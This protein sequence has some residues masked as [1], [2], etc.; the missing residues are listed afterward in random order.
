M[1]VLSHWYNVM[2]E[3]G[4]IPREQILGKEAESKVPAEFHAQHRT[5]AN[6]PTMLL[7]I[8]RLIRRAKADDV[9]DEN[10]LTF[11]KNIYP[12]L[13]LHFNWWVKTQAGKAPNSFRWRGRKVNHTLSS[14]LDDYPR[15][16]KPSNNE[17][18]VDGLCWLI[19]FSRT[20]SDIARL[21][22]NNNDADV[23]SQQQRAFEKT[24][25]TF[26]WNEKKQLYADS[27]IDLKY[28]PHV[29]LGI[30]PKNS[31][32]LDEYLNVINDSDQLWS[33]WGILSLSRNDS[34]F[35]TGENYWK[36][37]IW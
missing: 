6:P 18:H 1:D 12:R 11:L 5:H 23:L 30:I 25:D 33:E 4:W 21:L 27:S 37:P 24:L 19:L 7:A 29:G 22:N 14:G 28:S 8:E 36:G 17:L 3:D 31:N 10:V 26:H 16:G 32:K 9:I 15:D 2:H 35:G 20:L 13:K 34:Y